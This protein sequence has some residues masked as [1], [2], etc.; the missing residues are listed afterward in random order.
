MAGL[1]ITVEMKNRSSKVILPLGDLSE[2]NIRSR[3]SNDSWNLKKRIS[4][5]SFGDVYSAISEWNEE[6]AIKIEHVTKKDALT[7]LALEDRVYDCIHGQ[8]SGTPAG[9]ALKIW[10]GEQVINR[11]T[12]KILVLEKLGQTLGNIQR[13]MPRNRISPGNVMRIADQLIDGLEMLHATGFIHRDI[14]PDNIM[15]GLRQPSIIYLADFGISKVYRDKKQNH[16]TQMIEMGFV[17]TRLYASPNAHSMI[18]Q[19]RRDDLISLGYTLIYL[20]RGSLPWRGMKSHTDELI[21]L[22]GKAKNE[23]INRELD[24]F[25]KR[26]SMLGQKGIA[27][28]LTKYDF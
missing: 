22:I 2:I 25:V 3:T 19:S 11:K 17:G 21:K 12:C 24:D 28:V 6:V 15:V 9:F 18:T 10:Y 27:F 20:A 5:G 13:N 1:D 14:K 4:S 8:Y 26:Q 23:M 7:G 16:I